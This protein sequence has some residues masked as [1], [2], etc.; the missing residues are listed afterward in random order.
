[1][2]TI[3]TRHL[4]ER[5]AELSRLYDAVGEARGGSGGLVL[6]EGPAGAGK[7]ALLAAA[8]G[9]SDGLRVLRATGS[10]HE[11]EFAFGAIR[12]LFEPVLAAADTAQRARL[13]AGAAAPAERIVQPPAADAELPDVGFVADHALYWLAA[14][15]R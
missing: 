12:Q 6:V 5:D 1:V 14:N 10:E 8:V 11:R 9:Y 3:T 2:S 13:L 4:L 15:R 7:S